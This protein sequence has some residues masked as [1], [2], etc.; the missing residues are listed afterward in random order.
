MNFLPGHCTHGDL[1]LADGSSSLEGRV[2]MCYNEEWGTICD[3]GWRGNMNVVVICRQLGFNSQ[4]SKMSVLNFSLVCIIKF[5]FRVHSGSLLC[6]IS[7]AY[8]HMYNFW[9]TKI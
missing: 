8:T 3:D 7:N 5:Y 9:C 4:D 2:E 1:H 6:T